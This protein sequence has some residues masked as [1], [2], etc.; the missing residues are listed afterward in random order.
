M[1][2]INHRAPL[3]CGM[4]VTRCMIYETRSPRWC[5]VTASPELANSNRLLHTTATVCIRVGRIRDHIVSSYRLLVTMAPPDLLLYPS[6]DQTMHGPPFAFV[7]HVTFSSPYVSV[8]QGA[9]GH[10]LARS[11]KTV[12]KFRE[13]CQR[14][15]TF[16]TEICVPH[17]MT[18][19]RIL[20]VPLAFVGNEKDNRCHGDGE[21]V[22]D[23]GVL[24]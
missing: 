16:V 5:P 10:H 14:E 2:R 18:V 9:Q 4:A 24:L 15:L 8:T 23:D 11:P 19:P 6:L 13:G 12:Q 3:Q 7:F 21:W 22:H 1:I 17:Y 20:G